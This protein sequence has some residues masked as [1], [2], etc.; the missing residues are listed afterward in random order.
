MTSAANKLPYFTGSGTGTTTDLTSYIRTLLDDAT[1][2]EART[3]LGVN[4]DTDGTLAAN[5][6]SNIATQKATKTYVDSVA[7][8]GVSWKTA[9]RVATTTAGTLASDFEN[10]DTVDGVVLA[11]GD[12]ILIK[13]QAAPAANGIYVVAASGAPTRATDADTGAELVSAAVFVS[14]GTANHDTQWTCTANS[15][16][17]LGTDALP[18]VQIGSGA[19]LLQAANNLSDVS[20]ASTSRTNLGVAYATSNEIDTGTEAAKVMSPDAFAG[21]SRGKVSAVILGTDPNGSAITTGDGKVYWPVPAIA[22][23]MNLVTAV[24]IVTTASSSGTPTFQINNTTQ[25]ADMLTTRITIDANETTSRSA[26]TPAVIDTGN[27]DV[28]TGDVLRF[29][30]DVAGTGTKGVIFELEFQTP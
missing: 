9:V 8:A 10:G 15:P 4:L 23:G 7:T 16:I 3:T 2:A 14:E 27:D 17:N 13:D 19:G 29:D 24:A 26:A 1:A 25:A 6:D 28:A 20:N 30:F 18:W 21:S 11:T 22:N 5:S 12:R